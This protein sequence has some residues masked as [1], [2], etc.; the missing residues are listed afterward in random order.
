MKELSLSLRLQTVADIVP[1]NACL[2]DIGTD[3]AYLPAYLCQKGIIKKAIAG[4]VNE[5]PYQAAKHFVEKLSLTE[6]ISVR[7]G[8]G[9]AVISENDKVDVITIC[10]MGGVLIT[11][12]LQAEKDRLKNVKRLILQ[13][14]VA[15]ES[16][17]K[18]LYENGWQLIDERIIEENGKIYEILVAER[19]DPKAPYDEEFLEQQFFVG[20][21]LLKE[22]NE[23]FIK[24]WTQEL[25]NWRRIIEQLER[26][27][28]T[29]ELSEKRRQLLSQ[30]QFVEE[31]L[32]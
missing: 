17:R 20:P 22:K 5:G 27:E 29:P 24:K 25:N 32:R 2:A 1:K 10:G 9:L 18:W 8:D 16:V 15:A 4:E 7:K 12:I 3:H 31:V 14:N 11:N 23:A 26:A 21:F 19:G 13:P 6:K 28:E 30:I